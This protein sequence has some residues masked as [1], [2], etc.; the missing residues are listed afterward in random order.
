MV[1]GGV[2]PSPNS[3][4]A[5]GCHTSTNAGAR[6]V[7]TVKLPF[8]D[9]ATTTRPAG[10][11][12][13]A[14]AIP[15]RVAIPMSGASS[16]WV[17]VP[18]NV[19]SGVK[20]S[21]VSRATPSPCTSGWPGAGAMPASTTRP[22]GSRTAAVEYAVEPKSTAPVALTARVAGSSRTAAMSPYTPPVGWLSTTVPVRN[23]RPAGSAR[24]PVP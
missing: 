15:P 10:S 3:R 8:E 14:V 20:V 16:A 1:A 19:V 5:T 6:F 13:T 18:L 22:A 24:R 9:P 4:N 11:V 21:A 12:A 23:T 17:P 2:P 7:P